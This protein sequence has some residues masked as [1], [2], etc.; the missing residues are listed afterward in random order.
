MTVF[1]VCAHLTTHN[2][3]YKLEIGSYRCQHGH[4]KLD[5]QGKYIYSLAPGWFQANVDFQVNVSQCS[6]DKRRDSRS[7][8]MSQLGISTC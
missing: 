6:A 8:H 3:V 5:L 1:L 2:V 7:N 4:F